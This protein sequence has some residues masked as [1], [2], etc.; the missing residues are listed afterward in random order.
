MTQAMRLAG[1]LAGAG[2]CVGL[3]AQSAPVQSTETR[4]ATAL[5]ESYRSSSVAQTPSLYALYS[6]RALIH[7]YNRERALTSVFD[8]SVYKASSRQLLSQGQLRLEASEFHEASVEKRGERW[9]IRAQRFSSDRCYW[10]R[11]Y[12]IA[13][14][15]EYGRFQIV[16]EW[17]TID[18]T[19]RCTPVTYSSDALPSLPGALSAPVLADWSPLSSA[20][21]A[22][23]AA[24]LAG[25]VVNRRAQDTATNTD[26][27]DARRVGRSTGGSYSRTDTSSVL[28]T[29]TE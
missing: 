17:M 8:G 21:I 24:R 7:I 26:L 16:E 4:E 3:H 1:I 9:L 10:D 19:A 20:E 5:L 28:V 12:R 29:P 13:L 25:A 22:A 14:Q 6:D 23:T 18:P 27:A 2:L 11:D 15:R